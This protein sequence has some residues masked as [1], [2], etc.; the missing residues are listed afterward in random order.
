MNILRLFFRGT[1]LDVE[2][3][4]EGIVKQRR[5]MLVESYEEGMVFQVV[6]VR[7]YDAGSIFG[8]IPNE[9]ADAACVSYEHLKK[10]INEYVFSNVIK[11]RI[12]NYRHSDTFSNISK[13]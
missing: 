8:Y 13:N 4:F 5:V 3:V 6:G 7:G 1:G 10:M 11:M 9:F 12:T 2:Y